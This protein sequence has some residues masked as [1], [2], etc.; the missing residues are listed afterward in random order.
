MSISI[1]PLDLAQL[2]SLEVDVSHLDETPVVTGAL[3][4]LFILQAAI[5]A[6][7]KG[8]PLIWF[9]PFAFIDNCLNQV[10]GTGG[11]KGFPVD[12]RVEIGYGVAA[13]LRRN[14][15]ATS[16]VRELLQVAFSEPDVVEVYAETA[17]DNLPS[18]RVV[19][20]VGF[21]HLGQRATG[22]DGTVDQWLQSK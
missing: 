13:Q 8:K 11:F 7:K 21:R 18:R 5:G 12:R 10:V 14:G 17:A 3:P 20:R 2:Q 4:P 9:S 22:P 6:L 1:A 16:A 15:F 19:E